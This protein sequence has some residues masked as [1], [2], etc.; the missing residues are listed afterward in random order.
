MLYDFHH[1]ENSKKPN[2]V[3]ATYLITG[4]QKSP[5]PTTNGAHANGDDHEDDVMASSPYLPSSMPNQDTAAGDIVT[6]SVIL[7]REEDLEGRWDS[8]SGRKEIVD[9][10]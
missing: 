3:N 2:S 9:L 7:T 6:T 4:I 5:T 8:M 1:G 10:T